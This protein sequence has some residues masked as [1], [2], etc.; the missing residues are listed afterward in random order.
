MSQVINASIC[1]TELIE[2]ANKQ[3]SAFSRSQKNQKVYCNV[4]IWVNDEPD[5]YGNDASI[6]LNSSKDGAEKDKA[7]LPPGKKNFY[8][9]NGK[10]G[11]LGGAPLQNA[12]DL[13]LNGQWGGQSAQQPQQGTAFGNAWGSPD[14]KLPF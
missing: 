4:T 6:Q 2:L 14:G 13:Q 10:K 12:S 9:G 1:V 7:L 3:H 5:Q 8:L 11:N